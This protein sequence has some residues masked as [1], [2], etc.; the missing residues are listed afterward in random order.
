MIL[1]DADENLASKSKE[2]F[3]TGRAELWGSLE[4]PRSLYLG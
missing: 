1:L 4:L 3:D 2:R